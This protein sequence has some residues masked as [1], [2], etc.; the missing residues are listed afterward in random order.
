MQRWEYQVIVLPHTRTRDEEVGG[1]K[2]EHVY[3]QEAILN[4]YGSAGWEVVGLVRKPDSFDETSVK[5][6]C[7]LK[8]P[9]QQATY[10]SN[11]TGAPRAR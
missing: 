5:S 9:A 4:E 10:P 11:L 2:V 7:V 1:E 3:Q 8:R 6:M